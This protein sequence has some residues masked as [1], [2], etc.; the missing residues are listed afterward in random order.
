M[1]SFQPL[2]GHFGQ[3][4]GHVAQLV[5]TPTRDEYIS[6]HRLRENNTARAACGLHGAGIIT[7]FGDDG[8]KLSLPEYIS[9]A[10]GAADAPDSVIIRMAALLRALGSAGCSA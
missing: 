8:A 1:T 2:G 7:S 5:L 3:L 6:S 9:S 4:G 10:G